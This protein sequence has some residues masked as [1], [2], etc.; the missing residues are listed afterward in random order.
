M[1]TILFPTDFSKSDEHA[2]KYAGMLARSINARVVIINVHS[3]IFTKSQN[4]LEQCRRFFFQICEKFTF[5][6]K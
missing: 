4:E 5:K 2:A 3:P 1:K 6:P